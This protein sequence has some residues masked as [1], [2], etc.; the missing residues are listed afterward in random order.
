MTA[1]CW[2]RKVVKG[3]FLNHLFH[4][5]ILLLQNLQHA[6]HLHVVCSVFEY[7]IQYH[8]FSEACMLIQQRSCRFIFSQHMGPKYWPLPC[9]QFCMC[10]R[11]Y[12]T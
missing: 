1:I 11:L 6:F 10:Y 12:P 7:P 2:I 3:M 8:R 9:S 5:Q 4:H